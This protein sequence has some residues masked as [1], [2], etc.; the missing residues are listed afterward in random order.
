MNNIYW[1]YGIFGLSVLLN[2][3]VIWYLKQLLEKF[4]FF[5][6][7]ISNLHYN[8]YTF[9]AHLKKIY[10]MELFYGEPVLEGLIRHVGEV[11]ENLNS[12]IEIF[13]LNDTQD[14]E[15]WE[16]FDYGV[17]GD[18]EDEVEDEQEA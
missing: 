16:W 18:A 4:T 14:Y 13:N 1:V 8:I 5:S 7:N 2:V 15:G 12:F 6:E 3:F 10:E 11:E 17:K 9:R